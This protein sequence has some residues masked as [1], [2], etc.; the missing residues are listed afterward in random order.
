M[1][2]R[3]RPYSFHGEVALV[4]ELRL[5]LVWMPEYMRVTAAGNKGLAQYL[6]QA[7]LSYLWVSCVCV[8]THLWVGCLA[9]CH[10]KEVKRAAK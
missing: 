5:L 8:Y 1:F 10:A 7:G 2:R 6:T 3:A 9:F 4:N